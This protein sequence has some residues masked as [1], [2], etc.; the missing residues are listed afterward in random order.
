MSSFP[1]ALLHAPYEYFG[2]GI[3]NLYHKQG[4][5]HIP[6]LLRYRPNPDNTTGKLIC[7]GL[8]TL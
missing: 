6:S 2:L 8:E 4:I 1:H 3:T 7:L 5:Q